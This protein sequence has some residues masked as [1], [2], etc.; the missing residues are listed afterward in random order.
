[1]LYYLLV[2]KVFVR[3]FVMLY[4]LKESGSFRQGLAAY[5]ET[6][7]AETSLTLPPAA[8]KGEIRV[9]RLDC[10]INLVLL[11]YHPSGV[12]VSA[13]EDSDPVMGFSF[14]LSGKTIMVPNGLDR[15]IIF[16]PGWSRTFYHPEK[17]GT[18]RDMPDTPVIRISIQ[19][20]AR[21]FRHLVKEGI[22]SLPAGI[23]SAAEQENHRF[24]SWKDAVTPAMQSV[25]AQIVHCPYKGMVRRLF[26]EGK[27]M[28]LA[29]LKLEQLKIRDSSRPGLPALRP[30]DLDR[31]EA[32]RTILADNFQAPPNLFE[33]SRQVGMSRT[34]L[35]SVFK[36]T[37]GTTPAA[38]VRNLRLEKARR[39]LESRRMNVSEAAFFVGYS[40]L[41][42]FARAYKK[43]YGTLPSKTLHP[44]SIT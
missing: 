16:T 15:K 42:H 13:A 4:I 33:L 32:A 43:Y 20:S 3:F 10:G 22:A 35:L 34:K 44:L 28:E 30:E 12:L 36:T 37:Y 26:L 40:N 9:T 31:A 21:V 39:L 11:N 29:A 23:R 27:T 1:M 8:G 2:C 19:M 18:C 41:S 5:P 7:S 38:C 6:G 14:S 24:L 25:L 17:G